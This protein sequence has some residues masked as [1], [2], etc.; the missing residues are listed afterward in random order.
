MRK[1]NSGSLA[2]PEDDTFDAFPLSV[3]VGHNSFGIGVVDCGE[4]GSPVREDLPESIEVREEWLRG[5]GVAMTRTS[6]IY[7][8]GVDEGEYEHVDVNLEAMILTC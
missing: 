7:E 8:D 5:T 4:D 6:S 3:D 1:A 2:L